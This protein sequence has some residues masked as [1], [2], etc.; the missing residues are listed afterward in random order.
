MS[1]IL[2]NKRYEMIMSVELFLLT[3]LLTFR[4][5]CF[6]IGTMTNCIEQNLQRLRESNW[7]RFHSAGT[8]SVVRQDSWHTQVETEIEK[9]MKPPLP[10]WDVIVIFTE[11]KVL[12]KKGAEIL[13]SVDCR[14]LWSLFGDKKEAIT[15][16]V[17]LDGTQYEVHRL[18]A[19]LIIKV[20]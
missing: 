16:G 8:M 17:V 9:Y 6:D 12:L 2:E 3:C 19:S 10:F 15:S 5:N 4:E 11:N 1:G 13:Q 18:V 7:N 14:K 20:E